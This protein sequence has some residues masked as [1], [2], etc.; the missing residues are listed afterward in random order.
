MSIFACDACNTERCPCHVD[1]F[2]P[3]ILRSKTASFIGMPDRT[4]TETVV[5][6]KPIR[7]Y[8]MIS[9]IWFR[10]FQDVSSIYV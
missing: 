9:M 1:I 7:N 2:F 3:H 4:Q 5:M 6:Y 10:M 8:A